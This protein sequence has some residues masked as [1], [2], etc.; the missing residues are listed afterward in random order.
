MHIVAVGNKALDLRFGGEDAK[1]GRGIIAVVGNPLSIKGVA[2]GIGI[3][4][5][6]PK[7]F[8]A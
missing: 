1:E 4:Q 3:H 2:G 6:V 7:S 5:G 8:L